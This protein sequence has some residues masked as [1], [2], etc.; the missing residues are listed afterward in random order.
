LESEK[1]LIRIS[2]DVPVDDEVDLPE[3]LPSKAK[4][5]K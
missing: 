3:K 2:T 5:K 4:T 1:K